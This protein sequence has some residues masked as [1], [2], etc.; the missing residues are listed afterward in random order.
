ML[1][2]RLLI[3]LA[4]LIGLTALASGVS[5]REP[6]VRQDQSP[7]PPAGAGRPAPAPV[8]RTL[9][10]G[11]GDQRVVARVGQTVVITV[12]GATLDTVRLAEHGSETVDRD[13]PARFELL[14]DVPGSYAIDLLESDRR[15]GTLEIRP[16]D[17]EATGGAQS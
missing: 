8:E 6:A 14:A 16:E 4:V 12:E 2:R 11:A 7:T 13:S 15:I 3:V 9:D 5:P 17:G 1:A 10:A